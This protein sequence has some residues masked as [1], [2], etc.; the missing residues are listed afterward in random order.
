MQLNEIEKVD[1]YKYLG[2]YLDEKLSWDKHISYTYNPE[3]GEA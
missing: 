3:L 1:I 2:I